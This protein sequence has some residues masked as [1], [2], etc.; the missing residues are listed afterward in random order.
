MDDARFAPDEPELAAIAD[1]LRSRA[2]LPAL[3]VPRPW[4]PWDAEIQR[5]L[6]A[7][8]APAWRGG[9]PVRA[10]LLLWNDALGESHT[11]S[12]GMDT[13]S[14]SYWHGIMHR[15]EGDLDNAGYWFRRVGTHPVFAAL[16][17]AALARLDGAR[18]A[19]L[20]RAGRW[21]PFRFLDWC[22]AAEE[23]DRA[24]AGAA[25]AAGAGAAEPLRRVQVAEIELLLAHG[26]V[27]GERAGA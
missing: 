15:R 4:T 12:Q 25:G 18:R 22:G 6:T 1:R 3:F 26:Y 16:Y 14:G 21:D 13:A 2:P 10:G 19:D 27:T 24:A 8:P 11:L 7:A 23:D 17:P 5:T 9:A 20:D